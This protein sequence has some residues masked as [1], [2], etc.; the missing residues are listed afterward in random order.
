MRQ[1]APFDDV[2]IRDALA[3]MLGPD[4]VEADPQELAFYAQD[5]MTIGS[6]PIALVR[7]A[8]AFAIAELVTFA[9]TQGVGLFARGGGMSYSRAFQPTIARALIIDFSQL[10]RIRQV[11]VADGHVTVEAGCTWAA[12]DAALA[13]HGMRARFWG[14]MSGGTATIGGS[15]SQGSVTFGSGRTGAS[16]NAVKSFEVVTGTG[17][18]LQT[19]SNAFANTLPFNRNFGPDLTGLFAHDAGALGIKT[20]VTLELEPRPALVSGLSFAI[21]DF[22]AMVALL[23]HVTQ[24]RMASEIMAMDADVARQTAGP[25]NLVEDAKAMWR[26]G[27]AAG[28]PLSA[29][30]RMARIALS[31]RRFL[32]TAKYTVHFVVE[33]R[34]R[35]EL[36]S[37][38]RAIRSAASAGSE[39]VNTVPLMTRAQ[40]F[41]VLSVT[42]PDGRRMLPVHGIFAWSTVAAFHKEYLALKASFA[43]RMAATNVTV[44]EFFAAVAGIGLLY[45]PVFYWPDDLALY[46]QRKMPP[47]LDGVAKSY[48]ANPA[49]RA[50]VEEMTSAI[51]ACMRLH[52]STHFQIGRL[53]PHA[54]I[55]SDRLLQ[56]L[57]QVLDPDNII[58][59][60]ALGL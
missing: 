8:T 54:N 35:G 23:S 10:A 14:P 51:I 44:A 9:R 34:D 52:G 1:S 20:A 29:I 4:A 58:N 46:H 17:D 22:D 7:P 28:N 49:A 50:L 3:A 32:D 6:V 30:W 2:R 55:R 37:I 43:A 42:H 40:P 27:R 39:I 60:G 5:L 18:I 47:Y 26:V 36:S 24:R 13:P 53:Y 33:A 15:I 31:G 19:G 48:P 57:K 12:L 38:M 56:T 16:A 45:E 41:P 21:D 11:A 59:P 25:P